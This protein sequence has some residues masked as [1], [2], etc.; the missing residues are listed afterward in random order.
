MTQKPYHT[1]KD[2]Q[3]SPMTSEVE[4]RAVAPDGPRVRHL[5]QLELSR[6]WSL[7][8]RTLERWRWLKQGPPYLKVV[9][10]VLYRLED[11]EIYEA[12]HMLE[13]GQ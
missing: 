2:L 12:K 11:I 4:L 10:R 13:A 1:A 6:R 5:T 3:S 8:P 9:G 7:S